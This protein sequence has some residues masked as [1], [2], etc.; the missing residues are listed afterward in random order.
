MPLQVFYDGACPLCSREVAHYRRRDIHS[1]IAW[2]DIAQ[3]SFKAASYG[4]DSARIQQVMHARAPDGR[5]YTEV[6][7]FVEIWK[8]LPPRVLTTFLRGLLKIPGMFWL[9]G[10]FYRAFA[11]NRYRL[12]G[13]YTPE[14]CDLP[15]TP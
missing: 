11:R 6:A 7:A 8:A 10:I 12:T 5:I 13:R 3:P 9:A 2:I 14:S 4:L 1:A 15:P